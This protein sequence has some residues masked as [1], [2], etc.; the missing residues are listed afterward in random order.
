MG[1]VDGGSRGLMTSCWMGQRLHV[2][3][4]AAAILVR[5][6]GPHPLA[7]RSRRCSIACRRLPL[8]L[9]LLFFPLFSSVSLFIL[10]SFLCYLV[11]S[12]SHPLF[13]HITYP[14]ALSFASVFQYLFFSYFVHHFF[15]LLF[16]IFIAALVLLLR[17]VPL[18]PWLI[19]ARQSCFH[20]RAGD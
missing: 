20:D 2:G 3:Q 5:A 17:R 14:H 18:F 6:D 11:S 1:T 16:F 9:H 13:P 15:Y 10:S 4:A 19:S 8:L 12:T 7:R